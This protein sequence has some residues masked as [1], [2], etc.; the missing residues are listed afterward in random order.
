MRRGRIASSVS[1]AVWQQGQHKEWPVVQQ[2]PGWAGA[3]S[4]PAC[5]QEGGGAH[6]QPQARAAPAGTSQMTLV[7]PQAEARKPRGQ[8]SEDH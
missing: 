7:A 3:H 6:G 2:H 8:H 1:V 4:M 5:G